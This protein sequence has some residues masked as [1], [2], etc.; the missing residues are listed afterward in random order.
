MTARV[1]SRVAA[2]RQSRLRFV[3]GEAFDTPAVVSRAARLR[4]AAG[5]VAGERRRM[6]ERRGH[7][8]D[9]VH[10][11]GLLAGS[12]DRPIRELARTLLSEAIRALTLRRRGWLHAAVAGLAGELA[13]LLA[14]HQRLAAQASG[15][16]R[17]PL[18]PTARCIGCG[19]VVAS[20]RRMC[21]AHWRLLPRTLQRELHEAPD[22]GAVQER[23]QAALARSPG[24]V[25]RTPFVGKRP[26]GWSLQPARRR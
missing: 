4:V 1:A 2:R 13:K 25:A 24:R 9:L 7:L 5:G 19:A 22:S 10:L 8:H 16:S 11:A 18:P 12:D 14:P 21:F 23:V 6:W 26:R 20:Y 3:A 17:T 15:V